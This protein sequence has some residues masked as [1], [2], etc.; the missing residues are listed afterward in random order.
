MIDPQRQWCIQIDVTNACTRKCSNC[1][2]L[3]GQVVDPFFMSVEQYERAISCLEDFPSESP[4]AEDVMF[5]GLHSKVIGMIGGEPLMHPQFE[6]LA[7][8]AERLIL[9]RDQRGLWTGI[10]WQKTVHYKTIERVFG[11][12][13][14]NTHAASVH[15]P[16]LTAIDELVL[17]PRVRRELIDGCWLQRLW[18]GT[19]TPKGLFFCEVAGAMDIVFNGPGGLP[20]EPG[21]WRRPIEDF[22][23]QIDR[24]CHRCGVPLNLPGRLDCDDLDDVTSGNLQS[25]PNRERCVIHEGLSGEVSNDPWRYMR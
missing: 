5:K 19:I 8:I 10:K 16:V 17:D 11:Y 9:D 25:L 22:R 4:P 3:I 24:W 18:S 23:D 14:N 13:N 2:R 7:R 6:D 1:T 21:C 20:V 12:I 15:T